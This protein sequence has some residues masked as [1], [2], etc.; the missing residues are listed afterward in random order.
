VCSVLALSWIRPTGVEQQAVEELPFR[1]RAVLYENALREFEVLCTPP[2]PGLRET[3]R[4]RARFLSYFAE[5]DQRC[6]ELTHPLLEPSRRP[7][8]R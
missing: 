2:R 5:C 7:V 4:E 1:Q 8:R 6:H 3:C